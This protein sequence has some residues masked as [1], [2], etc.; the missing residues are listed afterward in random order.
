M[1]DELP[2][3]ATID[4]V[5]TLDQYMGKYGS[6]LGKQVQEL[7]KP[8]HTPGKDPLIP[9]ETLR[10][11]LPGQHHLVTA[12]IRLLRREKVADISGQCGVGKTICG[13]LIAHGHAAGKPYRALVF[14]PPHLTEKW[15]GELQETIPG[16]IVRCASKWSDLTTLRNRPKPSGP[17]WWVISNNTAKLGPAWKPAFIERRENKAGTRNGGFL[18]CPKCANR[19]EREEKDTGIMKPVSA[20]ELAKKKID[21]QYC[22]TPLWSWSGNLKRWPGAAY[23]SRQLKGMFDY[24]ICD[25][26]HESK[27]DSTAIGGAVGTL[28]SACRK[29]ISMTGTK[30]G[31]QADHVRSLSFRLIPHRLVE[32]GF[33]WGD[34]MPFSERYGRIERRVTTKGNSLG[35]D[36]RNSRGSTSKTTKYVRPGIMPVLFGEV[37]MANTSFLSLEDVSDALPPYDE[38]LHSVQMDSELALEY[39]RIEWKLTQAVK[40]MAAKGDKRLLGTMLQTLLCYPDKPFGWNEVGYYERTADG[41]GAWCPVVTPAN[42][43][44]DVLRQKERELIDDC[45]KERDEGRQVWVYT[46]M[47]DKRDVCERLRIKMMCRGLRVMILRSGDV[48]PKERGEWIAKWGPQ[49]DVIISHPKLVETGVDLF[50]KKGNHNFCTLQWYLTGYSLFTLRQASARHYRIGQKKECR[51]KYWFYANTMQERAMML[52][53]QKLTASQAIEGKFSTEGLVAMAGDDGGSIEMELAKSLVDKCS[54]NACRAWERITTSAMMVP[55]ET[56]R[57]IQPASMAP[58]TEVVAAARVDCATKPAPKIYVPTING[59]ALMDFR[60]EK[61]LALF[62]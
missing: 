45:V 23:V 1:S 56:A 30:L 26:S 36:N 16:C 50:C 19:I 20:D 11:L 14:C 53:G 27:G 18:F 58:T 2:E 29:V 35:L 42:L 8:L 39:N 37:M 46:T 10:K 59:Q 60:A 51:T 32:G 40:E 52:M 7:I 34:H 33:A 4:E 9:V 31:G 43:S 12:N 61:Q 3:V 41:E 47:T 48:P 5:A 38:T 62:G 17:E 54:L 15:C 57:A 21:C 24:L 25:E 22:E 13:M 6:L 28:T 44:E 55:V 49:C